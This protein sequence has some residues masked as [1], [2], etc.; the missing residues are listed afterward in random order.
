LFLDKYGRIPE[1][2]V[3]LWGGTEEGGVEVVEYT[4]GGR[5]GREGVEAIV[6]VYGVKDS[7]ESVAFSL[8]DGWRFGRLLGRD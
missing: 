2:D 8:S 5:E 7:G 3:F 1:D 4:D 6:F